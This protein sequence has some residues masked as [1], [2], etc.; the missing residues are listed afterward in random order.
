MTVVLKDRSGGTAY[1][2]APFGTGPLMLSN[3]LIT[4]QS[5]DSIGNNNTFY[6]LARHRTEN[7]WEVGVGT[8]ILGGP[9][10]VINRTLVYDGTDGPSVLVSFPAGFVDVI[11][12]FPA[13]LLGGVQSNVVGPPS[14]TPGAAVVFA[15]TLGS[16]LAEGPQFAR[17]GVSI[18]PLTGPAGHISPAVLP[19]SGVSVGTYG[20]ATELVEFTVT[21]DGRITGVIRHPFAV[22]TLGALTSVEASAASLLGVITTGTRASIY[23]DRT[24]ADAVY[25]PQTSAAALQTQVNNVSAAI[26]SI[27]GAT[28]RL[29]ANNT[30]T[31]TNTFNGAAS[32]TAVT[33]VSVLQ[34]SGA[35]QFNAVTS[36]STLSASGPFT[37][38]N[39]VQ[40]NAVT[41]VSVLRASGIFTANADAQFNAVT[42]VSVLRAS[43]AVAFNGATSVSTVSGGGTFAIRAGTWTPPVQLTDATS[44]AVNMA[45]SNDFFVT[46]GGNRTV[47]APTNCQPGQGG[48]IFVHQDGTGGRTLA[49]NS[50]WRF[51]SSTAPTITATSSSRDA[52]AYEVYTSTIIVASP[53]QAV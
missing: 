29:G 6:Y 12:V 3:S 40:L 35:A 37:G 4:Y 43:G 11:S 23:I 18:A 28:A 33:S 19:H 15:D 17:T 53:I 38:N 31:A 34:A 14:S 13:A 9:F 22:S 16:Q 7:Y 36:V 52:I 48:L 1:S 10:P 49:W 30:F 5:V 46:L 41:S 20:S 24:A 51:P 26:T 27:N 32:F 21:V 47:E 45:L 39:T 44:I 2:T 8:V 25:F 50:V 42:S